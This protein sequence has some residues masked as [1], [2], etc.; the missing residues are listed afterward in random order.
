MVDYRGRPLY[1][2]AYDDRY[3]FISR[4]AQ[5][6]KV[7]FLKREFIERNFSSFVDIGANY[8]EFT[9]AMMG[10]ARYVIAVEPNP[11][12]S[13]C[14]NLSVGS[15]TSVK[16][17]EKAVVATSS[18]K[19]MEIAVDPFASGGGSAAES[20]IHAD[21]RAFRL[22]G[23][24]AQLF[25]FNVGSVTLL[26]VLKSLPDT[27]SVCVK[28]DI[29]GLELEVIH[30]GVD[31]IRAMDD[32]MLFFES[33]PTERVDTYRSKLNS[34]VAALGCD[35]YAFDLSGKAQKVPVEN[36]VVAIDGRSEVT[37]YII[38]KRSLLTNS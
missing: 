25:Y 37:E 20:V 16:L 36:G 6:N 24:R 23:S 11:F 29:E 33:L 22:N 9:L 31:Y 19:V 1:L 4:E 13:F 7:E 14:L 8:G 38:T 26:D 2:S 32:Y 15:D 34:I 12:V 10:T 18:E 17:L 35:V 30:P 5:G 28:L 3:F 27:R 21:Y